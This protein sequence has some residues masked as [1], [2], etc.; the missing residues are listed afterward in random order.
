MPE[1]RGDDEGQPMP[2]LRIPAPRRTTTKRTTRARS[3]QNPEAEKTQKP[4]E[5]LEDILVK[6][7]EKAGMPLPRR[8]CTEPWKGTGRRFRGDLCY[9]SDR[10]IVEVDGGTWSGGRHTSGGG[11]RRDCVKRALATI[12]GYRYINAT[13]DQVK[14][15]TALRWIQAI[16]RP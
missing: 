7:L 3:Q 4:K 15:G 9:L 16:M 11:Y 14:D 12:A 13:S 6:Q 1:M 8:Q 10:L 5:N 2:E